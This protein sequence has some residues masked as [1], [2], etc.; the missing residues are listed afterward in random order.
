MYDRDVVVEIQRRSMMPPDLEHLAEAEVC[1]L[2]TTGR[3]TGRPHTIEILVILI[4]RAMNMFQESAA[5][6]DDD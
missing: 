3:I 6:A 4:K 2:T 1:S 5:G